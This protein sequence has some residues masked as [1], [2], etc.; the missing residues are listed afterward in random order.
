MLSGGVNSASVS[1]LH[2]PCGKFR[3][4]SGILTRKDMSL[5][6]KGK[7][8]VTYVRCPMMVGSENWPINGWQAGLFEWTKVRMP[9]WMCSVTLRDKVLSIDLRERMGIE[10]KTQV[11]KKNWLRWLG[12]ITER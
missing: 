11:V 6:L 10:L 3:E 1:R 4:L 5:K 9:W 8:Y 2:V 12:C 7:V